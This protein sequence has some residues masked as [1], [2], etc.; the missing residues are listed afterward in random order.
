M[1]FTEKL[2]LIPSIVLS[3]INF[4]VRPPHRLKLTVDHDFETRRE[5]ERHELDWPPVATCDPS[6]GH[7]YPPLRC[8]NMDLHYK[9]DEQEALEPC[10]IAINYETRRIDHT[11]SSA[12]L[13]DN[14]PGGSGEIGVAFFSLPFLVPLSPFLWL[15]YKYYRSM[16]KRLGLSCQGYALLKALK[17]QLDPETEALLT[18]ALKNE[19]T[20]DQV[21]LHGRKE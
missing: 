16:E 14:G 11:Y 6:K 2:A 9:Y 10:T 20:H 5:R 13:L 12:W 17:G 21:H 8:I 4:W 19:W 18:E 1:K 7:L 15:A 3:G